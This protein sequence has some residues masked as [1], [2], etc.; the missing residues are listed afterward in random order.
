MVLGLSTFYFGGVLLESLHF[1]PL[2]LSPSRVYLR[3]VN[4]PLSCVFIFLRQFVVGPC[5][6][7]TPAFPCA[8]VIVPLGFYGFF[9]SC[10]RPFGLITWS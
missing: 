2:S 7:S 3:L 10:L 4:L 6:A 9:G 5:W 8:S 1:L